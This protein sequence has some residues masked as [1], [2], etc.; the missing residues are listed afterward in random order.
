M[1]ARLARIKAQIPALAEEAGETAALGDRSDNAAYKEAK[2]LLRRAQRQVIALEDQLTRIVEISPGTDAHGAVR[3]GSTVTVALSPVEG[4]P[5]KG[6][7]STYVIVGPFETDPLSGRISHKSPLGAALIG[8]TA[9]DT[10]TVPTA[11][12]VRRYT[13]IAVR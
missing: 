9:G 6:A 2:S 3:L 8:K 4:D 7:S 12:G 11:R 10:I 5:H 13:I 1:K